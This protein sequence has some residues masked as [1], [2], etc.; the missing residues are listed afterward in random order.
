MCVTNYI[1]YIV[2]YNVENI[3]F[4]ADGTFI[5]VL[6]EKIPVQMDMEHVEV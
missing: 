6:V 5:S 4:N 1:F 3:G 2:T